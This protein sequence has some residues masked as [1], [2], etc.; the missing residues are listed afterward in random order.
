MRV[1]EMNTSEVCE[2]MGATVYMEY[3]LTN[4]PQ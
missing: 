2:R 3:L 1:M 4:Y